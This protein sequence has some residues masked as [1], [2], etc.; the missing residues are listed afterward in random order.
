MI[1]SQVVLMG[2]VQTYSASFSVINDRN[3]PIKNCA[4]PSQPVAALHGDTPSD[5]EGST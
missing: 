5:K 3:E 2:N 4:R 1:W